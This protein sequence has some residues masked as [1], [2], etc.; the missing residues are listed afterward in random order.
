M[1]CSILV[2][3][4]SLTT[5]RDCKF[6]TT[7]SFW[8]PYKSRLPLHRGPGSC[9]EAGDALRSFCG[10]CYLGLHDILSGFESL[11]KVETRDCPF[12]KKPL[13]VNAARLETMRYIWLSSCSVS[14]DTCKL[15]DES[16][17][18]DTRPE[19]F[20]VEKLYIYRTV[21][22]WRF[23]MPDFLW[24]VDGDASESMSYRTRNCSMDSV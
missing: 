8:P 15:L 17:H 5:S 11:C 14:H 3:G 1:D 18:P 4:P 7:F 12:G 24:T 22:G 23:N 9:K 2:L 21:V 19:S 20:L 16:G 13:L 10:E 6:T